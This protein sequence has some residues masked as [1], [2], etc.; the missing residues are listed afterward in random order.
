MSLAPKPHALGGV[1][2]LR[3]LRVATLVPI[4]FFSAPARR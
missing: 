3:G 4:L 2:Q 1:V